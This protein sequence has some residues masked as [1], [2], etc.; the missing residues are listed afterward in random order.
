MRTVDGKEIMVKYD[1]AEI[2][3]MYDWL[4]KHKEYKMVNYK[5]TFAY[6]YI[7]YYTEK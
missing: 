2:Y 4:D 1:F 6:G 7:L 5:F 3:N